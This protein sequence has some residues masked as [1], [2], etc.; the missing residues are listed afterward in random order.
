MALTKLGIPFEY[1]Y[2]CEFDKYAIN[3][4]NAVHGTNFPVTDVT[5]IGGDDLKI[6]NTDKYTYLL[7]YSFP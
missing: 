3:S 5:K 6:T 4:F 2:V 7:T 1:H